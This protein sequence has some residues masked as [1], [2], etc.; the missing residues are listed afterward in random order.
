[1]LLVLEAANTAYL[2]TLYEGCTLPH[3]HAQHLNFRPFLA[4]HLQRRNFSSCSKRPLRIREKSQH[5]KGAG[6]GAAHGQICPA[7][8]M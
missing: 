4:L 6:Q 1:M 5:I 3:F 8:G 2:K 7:V